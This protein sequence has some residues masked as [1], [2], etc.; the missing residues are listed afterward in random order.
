MWEMCINEI[1]SGCLPYSLVIP[2][3]GNSIMIIW[4]WVALVLACTPFSY[5]SFYLAFKLVRKGFLDS[6]FN[7]HI[8]LMMVFAGEFSAKMTHQ[9]KFD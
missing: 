8:A 1:I 7:Q 5:P 9:I 2:V 3:R 4:I 6:L